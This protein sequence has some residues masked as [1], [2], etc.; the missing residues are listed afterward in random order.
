MV[1]DLRVKPVAR[2]PRRSAGRQAAR[3]ASGDDGSDSSYCPPADIGSE[4]EWEDSASSASSHAS[5]PKQ[6]RTEALGHPRTPRVA[7]EEEPEVAP[8]P[9]NETRVGLSFRVRTNNKVSARNKKIK[10]SGS[11]KPL[12]PEEWVFYGKTFVCTHAGKYNARG[13]GKRKRQQSRALECEAQINACVQVVDNDAEV[14]EFVVRFTT[15]RLYH[16]HGL[17]EYTFRQYPRNRNALESEVLATVDTLRKAGASKKRIQQYIHENSVCTPTNQDV[18]N[19]VRRL[20]K[21]EHT[22]S[23]SAKRLKQWVQEFSEESGNVAGIFVD[24]V[25]NK[26]IAT[27]ITLQTAH[28]RQ[29][30]DF[31]PEVLMIDATHGTNSSKYKVFSIMAH[32]AFG[33]GQFVQHAVVQN[34][35]LPTL[36]TA[37]EEFKRNDPAWNR[38]RCILIDKDFTEISVLK[39]AFPDAVLLLC[40]FHVIKYLRE[41]IASA[42]YEFNAW[43][44]QQLQGLIQL[45]VYAKTEREYKRLQDYMHYIMGIGRRSAEL[46]AE[47]SAGRAESGA[48]AESN[49]DAPQHPFEAYF[50]KN[51]DKCRSMWCAFERQNAVTLAQE[52]KKF[53]DSL[54]KLSVVHDPKYD[55]EMQLLSNLISSHA[56]ELIYE[57]YVFATTRGKYKY[58]EAVPGV[59]LVQYVSDEEDALDEPTSTYSVMKSEWTCSCMF[60][61]SRL[62]PC[63]HVFYLRKALGFESITPTQLLHPRWLLTTLRSSTDAPQ[64]L[65]ASFAVSSVLPEPKATWDSNR[66][67]REANA[68]A[69]T[70]SEHLSGLGMREYRAAM[71][72]LED[73]GKLFKHGEYTAI[74][75]MTDVAEPA[76]A[77]Q[78]TE[79]PAEHH[80]AQ[81]LDVSSSASV[82]TTQLGMDGSQLGSDGFQLVSEENPTNPD[83]LDTSEEVNSSQAESTL[84]VAVAPPVQ[85]KKKQ[86]HAV[87]LRE[88]TGDFVL[89]SPPKPRGRPKQKTRA[90]KAK[91]SENAARVEEDVNMHENG[92]SLVSAYEL[93]EENPTFN[94]THEKLLQ[95]KLF[96]FVGKQKPPIAHEITKLPTNKPLVRPEEIVRMFSKDLIK[97]CMAKV[98]AYQRKH[99]GVREL[100]IA[101][102]ILG[103]GVFANSTVALM[104]KWHR[105][106]DVLKQIEKTLKWMK[107]LEFSRL[108]NSSFAV[109]EDPDLPEKLKAIGILSTETQ[110]LD[111]T[112]KQC[113]TDEV[114]ITVML[115][116][117]G[118]D[119]NIVIFDASALGVVVDGSVGADTASIQRAMR[120]LSTEI[121]LFPVNCNNNHWCSIVINLAKGKVS[122]YDSSSSSYLLGVRAVAQTLIP[123][124]PSTV[125]MSLRVQTYESGLGVQTDSYNCGIYV[126]IAF[127]IFCGAEPLGH[128]DKKTLQCLRYRYL[129]MCL[130]D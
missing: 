63:R 114:M 17:S 45:L 48:D 53:M 25:Q 8:P 85:A 101:L 116:K 4:E 38:I 20:K 109:E 57:Q 82:Q 86:Q 5:Q 75:R 59:F 21:R 102:E 30:F 39:M 29:L 66:K 111:L 77:L 71:K 121:V 81:D 43:Q 64:L 6:G 80:V 23:T 113:I 87:A 74:S 12:V 67:F 41:E 83:G 98:S 42:A 69:S 10:E 33:K 3:G 79:L 27:C 104:K 40:Q 117:F 84:P 58:K 68:V 105:A 35:R 97:K 32:D 118:P 119:P 56:C 54:F 130:E 22:A 9:F 89:E 90:V 103:V 112:A 126:L 2:A 88:A 36:L 120:G 24:S 26:N 122:I 91:R 52:E 99:P 47:L 100:D 124:L 7:D 96:V 128:L 127:E 16:N 72:V 129:R 13:Q 37:L 15:W 73:V 28:M 11:T 31:F 62:L 19:L 107:Q 108:A 92:L 51:W 65:G 49:D 1:H 106:C 78:S 61:T 115:K 14:P 50:D 93:L 60:M 76:D 18:R 110:V 70:N 94:S 34:E 55:R 125:E 46:D 44:K 95:F 123:L